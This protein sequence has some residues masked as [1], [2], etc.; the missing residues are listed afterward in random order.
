MP[1][2]FVGCY[3]IRVRERNT[4]DPLPLGLDDANDSVRDAV[5]R[6]ME[7]MRAT[8]REHPERQHFIQTSRIE[9]DDD[10]IWGLIDRGEFG[11]AARGFDRRNRR[12]SFQ[13][14]PDDAELLPF[15]FRF[16][17]PDDANVGIL[18]IQRTGIHGAFSDLREAVEANF[19]E[20]HPDYILQFGRFMPDRVLRQIIDG[21][22]REISLIS[23][24]LPDD[25]ADRLLLRG[26]EIE[27]GTLEIRVKAKRDS[28]L[29]PGV[30]PRLLRRLRRGEITVAE[31][32]EDETSRLRIRVAYNGRER[33][34][35]FGRPG[36][37]AP[38]IE[39]GDDVMMARSGHPDFDSMDEYCRELVAELL[40]QLGQEE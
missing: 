19:R 12:N 37:I 33:L 1:D 24:R 22:I 36:S 35:D 9:T 6:T 14:R 16:H 5:L 17:L 40:E 7:G 29:I 3:S 25:I 13:R 15:Y 27:L 26:T 20:T 2:I 8:G 18:L 28:P 30:Q 39:V 11:F 10:S 21:Q 4:R 31:V 34:F 23:H 38:Y 32:L